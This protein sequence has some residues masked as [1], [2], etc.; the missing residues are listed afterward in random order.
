MNSPCDCKPT[1]F[2]DS[3]NDRVMNR[4]SCESVTPELFWSDTLTYANGI[5]AKSHFLN[6]SG[7]CKNVKYKHWHDLPSSGRLSL[8]GLALSRYITTSKNPS[9]TEL[10]TPRRKLKKLAE[11][12]HKWYKSA[13]GHT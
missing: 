3:R 1:Q 12:E 9:A 7:Y 2:N 10:A 11:A 13:A 4:T 6:Q 5:Q 8:P